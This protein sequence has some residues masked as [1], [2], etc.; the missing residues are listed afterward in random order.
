MKK[1]S[2]ILASIT[3]MT[4]LVSGSVMAFAATDAT[5]G[6]GIAARVFGHDKGK[7]AETILNLTDAQRTVFQQERSEQLKT[8]LTT[9][10][11]KGTFTQV[12]ADAIIA[13][14]PPA[15]AADTDP[16]DHDRGP[17]QNL[18]DAQST[19]LQEKLQSLKPD[20]EHLNRTAAMKQ[21]ISELVSEGVLTQVEGDKILA[22]MPAPPTAGTTGADEHKGPFGSL[23]DAQRTA[24]Q[25]ELKTLETSMINQLVAD[26]TITQ[27]QADQFLAMKAGPIGGA[28]DRTDRGPGFGPGH[29]KAKGVTTSTTGE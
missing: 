26:G 16:T 9:L 11:S 14:M 21:A 18:T 13:N 1:R 7:G 10:V 23:T 19:A 15:P 6:A 29:D 3:A 12:E 4:I 20:E 25:A 8:A 17:F 5:T 28:D 2:I 24:L 27:T 22:D